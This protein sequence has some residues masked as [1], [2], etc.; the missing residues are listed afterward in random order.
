MFCYRKISAGVL[1]S[2]QAGGWFCTVTKEVGMQR[3]PPLG[4]EHMML[5][6]PPVSRGQA[7][8]SRT[9]TEQ[10]ICPTQT[11]Q[12]QIMYGNPVV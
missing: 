3:E 11:V 12:T 7:V 9:A 10:G 2:P 1:V 6:S 8:R 5:V 4:Q